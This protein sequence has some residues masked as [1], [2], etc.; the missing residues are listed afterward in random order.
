[1]K[2][3]GETAALVGHLKA[4]KGFHGP[5][6][7]VGYIEYWLV[8]E[9]DKFAID[10]GSQQRDELSCAVVG[11]GNAGSKCRM[12][13]RPLAL[14]LYMEITSHVPTFDLFN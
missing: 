9:R 12:Q 5:R 2:I 7:L 13:F 1:M 3:F 11:R 14:A 10:R 6:L 4:H 8:D